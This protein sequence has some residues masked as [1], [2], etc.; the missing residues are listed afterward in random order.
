VQSIPLAMVARLRRVRAMKSYLGLLWVGVVLGGGQR[1]AVATPSDQ[2]QLEW[3]A[4]K[5]KDST[6]NI[7]LVV[8][9]KAFP[10]G[11]LATDSDGED[12]GTLRAC[13]LDNPDATRSELHCGHVPALNYFEAKL[14]GKTL[15]VTLVTGV[16]GGDDDGK[17][18]RKEL[19]HIP[20][21]GSK[22]VVAPFAAK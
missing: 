16:T 13:E 10:I 9:G 5:G 18:T 11:T 6:A 8:A 3:K 14:A 1:E 12:D 17:L 4:T 21:A 2:V 19:K 15:T 7:T 22:L 20:V